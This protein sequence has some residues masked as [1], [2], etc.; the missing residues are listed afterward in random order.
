MPLSPSHRSRSALR[1][2]DAPAPDRLDQPHAV[3]IADIAVAC[4]ALDCGCATWSS[5]QVNVVVARDEEDSRIVEGRHAH[6][7]HRDV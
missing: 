1:P 2:N 6:K 5:H 7:V 3:T 4:T